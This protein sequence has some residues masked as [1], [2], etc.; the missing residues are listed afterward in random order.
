M[1]ILLGSIG[2][3]TSV[4]AEEQTEFPTPIVIGVD[5]WQPFTGKTMLQGGYATHL[6]TT[7]LERLGHPYKIRFAPWERITTEGRNGSVHLIPDMWQS[8]ERKKHYI[9]SIPV[10]NNKL[11]IINRSGLKPKAQLLDDLN[12]LRIGL[13]QGFQ[14]PDELVEN[15]N[16]ARE[17]APDN[18][19]NLLKLINGRIDVTIGDEIVARSILGKLEA[20]EDQYYIPDASID[21]SPL[22]IALSR[23]TPNGMELMRQINCELAKMFNDGTVT[24]LKAQHNLAFITDDYNRAFNTYARFRCPS[25]NEG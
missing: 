16:L 23:K 3:F 15:Q 22:H 21:L 10:L 6:L 19:S 7:V 13:V 12:G 5:E 11:K 9:F 17:L 18:R 4:S 14:Y 2:F 25:E 20:S 24:T 8:R 1:V